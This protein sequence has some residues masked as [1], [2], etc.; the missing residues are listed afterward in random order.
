MTASSERSLEVIARS[1]QKM[2]TVLESSNKN[3]VEIGRLLKEFM[4][5]PVDLEALEENTRRL[6]LVE[7]E[8]NQLMLPLKPRIRIGDRF[9]V[10]DEY[11]GVFGYEGSVV[12][13]GM[14]GIQGQLDGKEKPETFGL[15]SI[16][17]IS[18]KETKPETIKI[19]K[20][21]PLALVDEIVN[22]PSFMSKDCV[23]EDCDG[24][25]ERED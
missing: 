7:E 15:S 13:I 25:C 1:M 3:L 8:T 24:N 19:R 21:G 9:Q 16:Q 6:K 5:T 22:M 18:P 17:I 12:E 11:L 10:S 23:G 4:E 20:D 14:Y 2:V